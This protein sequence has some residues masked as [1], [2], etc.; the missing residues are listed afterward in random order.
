VNSVERVALPRAPV[1]PPM[2]LAEPHTLET[3]RRSP[4][5]DLA[6]MNV[7]MRYPGLGSQAMF[8]P[9]PVDDVPLSAIPE[10]SCWLD[11]ASS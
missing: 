11:E 2:K 10:L 4:G 8:N 3:D 7:L 9:W 5:H 6:S 1:R